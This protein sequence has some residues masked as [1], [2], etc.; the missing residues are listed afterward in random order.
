METLE[1]IR[2]LAAGEHVA[3]VHEHGPVGEADLIHI[4]RRYENRRAA[5]PE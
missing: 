1:Q 2:R 4:R 3:L 5:L